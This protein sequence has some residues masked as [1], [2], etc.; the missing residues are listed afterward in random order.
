MKYAGSLEAIY[1]DLRS[2]PKPS[3][4]HIWK[5]NVYTILAVDHQGHQMQVDRNVQTNFDSVWYHDQKQLAITD[6][7]GDICSVFSSEHLA[8]GDELVQRYFLTDTN[9]VLRAFT[10]HWR[11]RWNAVA[12]IPQH[13]WQRIVCICLSLHATV[14]NG[15]E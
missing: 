8:P 9:D 6:I 3:V 13:D 15:M 4:N 10:E 2:D 14:Q 7:S 12:D 1:M 11:P 5:E